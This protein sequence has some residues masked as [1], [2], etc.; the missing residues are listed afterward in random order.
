MRLWHTGKKVCLL[1][2]A[3][4]SLAPGCVSTGPVEADNQDLHAPLIVARAGDQAILSWDSKSSNVYSV[5]FTDGARFGGQWQPLPQA[6]RIVGT[7][8]EMRVE[9]R[10][11]AGY[12]RNYRLMIVDRVTPGPSR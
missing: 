2:L 4:V 10:V 7:G 6:Q 12:T 11:P 3:G 8:G 5:L 1:L 9:D